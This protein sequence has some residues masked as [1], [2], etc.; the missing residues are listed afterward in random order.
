MSAER[1]ELIN[2][3]F[4]DL[5]AAIQDLNAIEAERENKLY[6]EAL[7]SRF[8]LA[9]EMTRQLT[10]LIIAYLDE[11]KSNFPKET[12]EIGMTNG[13][14]PKS[15]G[16]FEMHSDRNTLA[17]EYSPPDLEKI[18]QHIEKDYSTLLNA[19]YQLLKQKV[20]QLNKRN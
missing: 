7:A 15:E 14:L 20:Q 8:R 19:G 9:Y 2:E 3:V 11:P 10:R 18:S 4:T 1:L 16:W 5:T 6:R 13:L 17:H 12:L